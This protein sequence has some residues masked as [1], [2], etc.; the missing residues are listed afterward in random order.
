MDDDLVAWPFPTLKPESSWSEYDRDFIDYMRIAYAEGFR[1]RSERSECCI[2]AGERSGRHAS[3]VYRGRNGWEPWLSDNGRGER[4][5]P[6]YNLPLGDSACV[7]V[8]PPFRAA[9]HLAL[10]WLRGRELDS[11]LSDFEFVGGFPAGITLRPDVV[12][13]SL[14]AR[15]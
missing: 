3:L 12:S 13:P 9:A 7:C 10:E 1:P 2:D 6:H 14:D 5:G 8:R 15:D 4:L 11:L